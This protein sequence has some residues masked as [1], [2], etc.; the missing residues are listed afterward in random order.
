[1]IETYDNTT[2]NLEKICIKGDMLQ[3]TL[4]LSELDLFNIPLHE[5]FI[6]TELAKKLAITLLEN[7]YINFTKTKNQVDMS[8]TYIARAAVVPKDMVQELV[9]TA[10][11]KGFLKVNP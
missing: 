9:K 5:D 2:F 7:N 4:N 1:M 11:V 3:C 6:K 10:Q 8:V